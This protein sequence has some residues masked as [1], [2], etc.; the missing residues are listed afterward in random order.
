[1]KR[2]RIAQM[3]EKE[4]TLF[5]L[6]GH[7]INEINVLN[8]LFYLSNQYE[9]SD[10]WRRHAHLTQGLV[11]ARTLTGKLWEAW[12]LLTKA[13]FDTKLSKDYHAK[14]NEEAKNSLKSLRKYFNRDNLIKTVRNSF[15]FHYDINEISKLVPEEFNPDELISYM[16]ETNGNTLFYLSEYAVNVALL[17]SISPGDPAGAMEALIKESSEVVRWFNETAQGIMVAAAEEYLREDD[18]SV[19]L[20]AIDIGPV[21][22]AEEIRLPFFLES[23]LKPGTTE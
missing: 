7:A 3:P 11:L 8:K 19:P 13:Y 17:D 9:A 22:V 12:K 6:L 5:F 14:L 10:N 23:T 20:E 4:R 16:S 2:E 1:M 18:G 21:P 15:S